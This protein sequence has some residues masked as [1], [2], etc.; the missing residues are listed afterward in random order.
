MNG[1]DGDEDETDTSIDTRDFFI[2]GAGTSPALNNWGL[3]EQLT[4]AA[5]KNEYTITLD[6]YAGD[7]FQLAINSSWSDQHGAGYLVKNEIEGTAYFAQSDNLKG[8]IT[9][10][11]E[12]NYTLTLTTNPSDSTQDTIDWVYN[13][14]VEDRIETTLYYYIKGTNVTPTF[15]NYIEDKY[16]MTETSEGVYE[17]T[18]EIGA[19][20]EFMFYSMMDDGSGTLSAGTSYIQGGQLENQTIANGSG[21]SNITIANAGTYKFTFNSSTNKLAVELVTVED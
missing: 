10:Q 7:Q 17:L 8:N 6:L 16:K 14:E 1:G 15:A 13:G 9:C 12:G 21:T 2:L 20:A 18:I 11:V 5:D 4:K 19:N 3:G